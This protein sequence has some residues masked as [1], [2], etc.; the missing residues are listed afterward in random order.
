MKR[1][2]EICGLKQLDLG[3]LLVHEYE[4]IDLQRL[5][6]AAEKNV[7]DLLEYLSDVFR[8]LGLA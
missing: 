6:Q 4:K 8:K 3:N 1:F 5:Y 2:H 7:D